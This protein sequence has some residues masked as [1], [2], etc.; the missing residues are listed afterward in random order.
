MSEQEKQ[1][2]IAKVEVQ[3]CRRWVTLII[4][5]PIFILII[6][7]L[8]GPIISDNL[9]RQEANAE[10][11]TL[12]DTVE[13][14]PN[15]TTFEIANF[16]GEAVI[17]ADNLAQMVL[18]EGEVPLGIEIARRDYISAVNHPD[19]DY[20]IYAAYKP[21][22]ATN[23]YICDNN[24]EAL[25]A[26]TGD[27]TTREVI[28][29]S[30]GSLFAVSDGRLGRIRLFDGVAIRQLETISIRGNQEHR[31]INSIA[32]HPTEHLIFFISE[33]ELFAYELENY[34]EVFR[35]PIFETNNREIGFNTDGTLFFMSA[36]GDDAISYIWGVRE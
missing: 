10:C 8:L 11:A 5:A 1:A 6:L 9:A 28:F 18:F 22:Y 7:T 13:A 35:V 4:L 19:N 34:S 2:A 23:F 3:G 21:S 29:N 33:N 14:V 20:F 26:F 16:S 24:G 32:F 31:Q 15:S 25:G 12:I 30:D 17:T 27:E 36:T